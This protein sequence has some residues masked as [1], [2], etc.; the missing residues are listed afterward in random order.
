MVVHAGREDAETAGC[1]IDLEDTVFRAALGDEE[2][3]VVEREGLGRLVEQ[4]RRRRH[5]D[6]P[7]PDAAVSEHGAQ[8]PGPR[9]WEA[10]ARAVP[11]RAES[12]PT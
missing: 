3:P 8:V 5:H 9:G 2:R 7:E 12:T 4:V 6:R 1:E 10:Q 11:V